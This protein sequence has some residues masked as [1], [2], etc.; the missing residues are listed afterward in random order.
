MT[1]FQVDL[2][3]TLE[4]IS[5]TDALRIIEERLYSGRTDPRRPVT[6]AD[7]VTVDVATVS[8]HKDQRGTA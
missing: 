8:K 2:R 7:A 4:A 6:D 3:V 1:R 5:N